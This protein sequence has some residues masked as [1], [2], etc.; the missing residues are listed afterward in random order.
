MENAVT[1]PA[2]ETSDTGGADGAGDRRPWWR[3]PVVAWFGVAAMVGFLVLIVLAVAFWRIYTDADIPSADELRLPDPS[4]LISADGDEVQNLRPAAVRENVALDELP[5]HVPEAV[6]AAEDRD[7]RD[8]GGFSPTGIVRAALANLRAGEIRQGASTINQQYVAMA[9]AEIDDSFTG[10]FREVATAARLDAELD[11]DQILENYLN[12]VPFG[13][14][15]QG[16]QA[17]AQT[18]FGV[19]ASELTLN[20]S[21]TLAGMIAAPSAYDP[22]RN[23]EGAARRRDFV[24]RGMSDTGAI[25][26]AAAREAM[27][28]PLPESRTEPLVASGPEA[29]FL[30]AVRRRLPGLLEMD[31]DDLD[32]GLRI[33]TTLDLRAQRLAVEALNEGLGDEPYAGA[34][35]TI[36]AT[37][38]AYRA[39]VG[40]RDHREQQFDVAV[41]GRRQV[42]SAFKPF[43]LA[44]FVAQGYDP[45]DTDIEAPEELDI[46]V[47]GG[48]DTTVRNFNDREYG[49]VTVREATVSSVNT[50]YMRMAE[51]LGYGR[52]VDRASQLG[53]VTEL[54]PYPS[55]TLGAGDL[56]PIELTAAYATFA[57]EG[58]RRQPYMVDRVE[59]HEG[60]VVFRHEADDERVMDARD[61]AVVTDVLVDVVEDGTGTAADLDR[62]NAGKTG[63]TNAYRDAWF[64]GYTPEY[65]TSVWVGNLDNSPMDGV[66]GG[67]FPA[68]IWGTYM[69]QLLEPLPVQRFPSADA[70]HLEPLE[71]LEAEDPEP[72]FE[73]PPRPSPPATESEEAPEDDATEDETTED[74]APEDEAPEDEQAP[75]EEGD[76]DDPDEP[77]NEEGDAEGDDGGD[78]DGSDGGNAGEGGDE[79]PSEGGEADGDEVDGEEAEGDEAAGGGPDED[80]SEGNEGGTDGEAEQQEQTEGSDSTDEVD[81]DGDG[82]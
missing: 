74:E 28:G 33:H 4:V 35:V 29:F 37:T 49:E 57:A 47:E 40:G 70:S 56:R 50:A 14:N 44:E 58:V 25:D 42:G 48:D 8:H 23:P 59:T 60:E 79:P 46:E 21:A 73:P 31:V 67:S 62:P 1:E 7:F 30:D 41:E 76:Q 43:A 38:G 27:E 2:T 17:A 22:E 72:E 63:T 20:Q 65:A 13:R 45:D 77:S 61:V 66:T 51:E 68:R 80:G 75:E 12:S 69:E 36:D 16:I 26:A 71:G 18:H 64:A 82:G 54:P 3:R 32:T 52:V 81:D 34:V 19:D 6:L 24:L 5:D 39:L 78:A 11:K 15:A 10:K 9:V 53:V 55:M